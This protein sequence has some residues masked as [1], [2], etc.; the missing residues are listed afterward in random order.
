MSDKFNEGLAL[1]ATGGGGESA[2]GKGTK[3]AASAF[4]D[5]DKGA[6]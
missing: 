1:A 5:C 3:S 4:S 6:I 2:S